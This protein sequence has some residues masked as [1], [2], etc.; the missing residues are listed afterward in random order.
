MIP[1]VIV[2][3]TGWCS[4]QYLLLVSYGDCRD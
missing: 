1:V 2:I 3:I 4:Y